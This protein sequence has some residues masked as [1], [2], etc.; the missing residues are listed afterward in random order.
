MSDG[1]SFALAQFSEVAEFTNGYAFGPAEWGTSGLPIIRIQQLLNPAAESD[2]CEEAIGDRYL[3]NTGDLVMSWGGTIAVVRWDRGPAWLNQHLF[4]VDPKPGVDDAFLE[5]VL[6]FSLVGLESAAHGTTMKHIKRGDLLQYEVSLPPL[7]EQR[8]IA[9]ILDTID[10][11]IQAT[12]RVVAKLEVGRQ[13]LLDDL[14]G[15]IERHEH[16]GDALDRID[17]G[18]SPTCLERPPAGAEWGVL[19]V[20]SITREE[21]NPAASKTLPRTLPPRPDLIVRVGDVLTARANGV[22]D[23]VGRTAFVGHLGGR[24]LLI[25]DKTLRL[26]PGRRLSPLYLTYCMQHEMVRSQVRGLVSGSTGQGN[27]SQAELRSLRL[28]I[29]PRRDQHAIEAAVTS[30]DDRLH[31][32][33]S[34]LSKL[35]TLRDGVISDLLSGRVRTSA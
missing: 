2:S 3:I 11:T 27:I 14:L 13:G 33:R 23:L 12:E 1:L 20:S 5:H 9:K 6:D 19:K 30:V 24:K 21:F 15:R 32:E 18:W 7:D 26:V 25:S 34:T 10:E 35:N 29:P 22:A 28:A 17:A 8:R 31:T 16:L 4:R